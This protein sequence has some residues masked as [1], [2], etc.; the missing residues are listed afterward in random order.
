MTDVQVIG[1]PII[2]TPG[3]SLVY[4]VTLASGLIVTN[5][6]G[7]GE[8]VSEEPQQFLVVPLPRRQ[9]NGVG[10]ASAPPSI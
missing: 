6:G 4:H 8:E 1:G 3:G 7:F 10:H 9:E 2:Q 5:P